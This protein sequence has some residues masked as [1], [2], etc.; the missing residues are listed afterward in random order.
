MDHPRSRWMNEREQR[1]R[2]LVGTVLEG[3]YKLTRLVGEGGMGAVFE[4]VQLRLDKRVAVKVMARELA[5]N[6]EALARFRRE[7][8]VTSQLAHPHIVH[9]S[10]FGTAPGGEPFL[11]MEYLQGEDLADRLNRVERLALPSAVTIIN[12]AAS[13][14]AATH[15][16]GIVHRDLKPENLFLLT[17]EGVTDFVKVVDFGISKVKASDEKLT[18]ASVMMGT[19][20]YMA[21][22]QATGRIDQID[23]RT[24]QWALACI[25]WEML[26]GNEPF[27]AKDTPT[28]LYSIVHREPPPL[29]VA[30]LP[31]EV[32]TVLRRALSKRQGDRFPTISA[33]ARA[34]GTATTPRPVVVETPRPARAPTPRPD[35]AATPPALERLGTMFGSLIPRRRRSRRG[36]VGLTVAMGRKAIEDLLPQ[37]RKRPSRKLAWISAAAVGATLAVGAALFFRAPAKPPAKAAVVAPA[38]PAP[39]AAAKHRRH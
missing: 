28:L 34:F 32:E 8:Q 15:G 7:V 10:D 4:A 35:R 30:G 31:P 37:R 17:V 18:R 14:L 21:P 20:A 16:K 2:A 25:A 22:E 36:I 5:A 39:P 33:F 27:V 26:S 6:A 19:P 11:V 38:P 9:V 29:E 3:A 24:D 13:A 23:H 12:Q 1:A